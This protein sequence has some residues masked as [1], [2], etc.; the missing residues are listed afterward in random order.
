MTFFCL[1][2]ST[3]LL[4]IADK[5]QDSVFKNL[6]EKCVER[7]ITSENVADLY[8]S[9]RKIKIEVNDFVFF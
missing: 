7:G 9:A 3:E 5:Y 1:F 4:K 2:F 6:C 8:M